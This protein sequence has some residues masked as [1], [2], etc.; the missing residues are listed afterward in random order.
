MKIKVGIA[1]IF[2]L[3][4]LFFSSRG[5]NHETDKLYLIAL[6]KYVD[7]VD[8]FYTSNKKPSDLNIIYIEKP[9]FIY[10]IPNTVNGRKIIVLTD[11]NKQKILKEHN[12]ELTYTIIKPLSVLGDKLTIDIAPYYPLK[13]GD[14]Y[15]PTASDGLFI[16]FKFNS[17]K[18]EFEYF[19]TTKWSH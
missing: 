3:S 4:F 16:V 9:A 15:Y 13:R 18:K 2:C 12:Q 7:Q 11:L 14:H 10:D 19:D 5:Q 6:E 17:D 1:L 8:S